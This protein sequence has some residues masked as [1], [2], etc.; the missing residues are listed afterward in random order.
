MATQHDAQLAALFTWRSAVASEH[1][2]DK[3]TTR[4]VLLT[5]GLHMNERG[6]SCFP[7]LTRLASETGLDRS[8]VTRHLR[9][10]ADDGWIRRTRTKKENGTWGRTEYV[11]TVPKRVREEVGAEDTH[12]GAGRNHMVGADSTY[13][14]AEDDG[15]RCT[16]PP[17]YFSKS[18]PRTAA[19][20]TART[21]E[22]GGREDA[23]RV[24][25]GAVE[26]HAEGIDD[27]TKRRAFIAGT[28]PLVTGLDITAWRD[29]TGTQRPW[30]E[31]P[32]LLQL[33]LSRLAAGDNDNLRSALRYVIPQQTDPYDVPSSDG[34]DRAPPAGAVEDVKQLLAHASST[35]W[36]PE[37]RPFAERTL[38]ENYPDLWRRAG[39]AFQRLDLAPIRTPWERENDY[40]VTQQL[41]EQLRRQ[42]TGHAA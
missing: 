21:R 12:I 35:L 34:A 40:A 3:P 18:T 22:G 36:H 32:A 15:G 17:E 20:A 37:G 19:T 13:V 1:G 41:R 33:A 24:M 25:R 9:E 23:E 39:P 31:R 26:A 7:S 16:A 10:A 11:A 27:P 6:S 42:A 5:L 8:T 2:P 30:P 29:K 14:G 4:H 28:D 38:A